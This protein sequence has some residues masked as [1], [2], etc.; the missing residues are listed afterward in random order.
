LQN[1]VEWLT[2]NGYEVVNPTNLDNKVNSDSFSGPSTAWRNICLSN[3]IVELAYST[4]I[5]LCPEWNQ[6]KEGI[7]IKAVAEAM[8]KEIILIP[9]SVFEGRY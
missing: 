8:N 4:H 1:A 6:W 2:T 7:A 3:D 9:D 5:A